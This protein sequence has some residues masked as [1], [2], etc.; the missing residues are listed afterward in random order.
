MDRSPRLRDSRGERVKSPG[1]C[2]GRTE[3]C[4]GTAYWAQAERFRCRECREWSSAFA[5][6]RKAS[7]FAAAKC[8]WKITS[9]HSPVAP[10]RG[11]RQVGL[12]DLP[13]W[14][15]LESPDGRPE[16]DAGARR[17]RSSREYPSPDTSR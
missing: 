15:L 7:N 3:S 9:I 12:E 6:N 5:W 4:L 13:G 2:E 17:G 8:G 16:P 11:K 10:P 1:R 14:M